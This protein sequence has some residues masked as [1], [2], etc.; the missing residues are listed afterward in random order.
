MRLGLILAAF[1]IILLG[2][3][4]ELYLSNAYV[5]GTQTASEAPRSTPPTPAGC[6]AV[7]PKSKQANSFG[8][9]AKPPGDALVLHVKEKNGS[10]G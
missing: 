8:C 5:S 3:K 1:G 2:P 10:H 7:A 6:V 4:T 9:T